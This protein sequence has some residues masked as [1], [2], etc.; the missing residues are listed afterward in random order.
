KKKKKKKKQQPQTI[1]LSGTVVHTNPVAVSYSLASGGNLTAVHTSDPSALPQV[2]DVV[3]SNA[4]KLKNGTYAEQAAKGKPARTQQG[5]SGNATFT[6][7]VTFCADV[8]DPAG[9][10]CDGNP[11]PPPHA[12]DQFVYTVSTIGASVLVRSP[13]PIG[14][15]APT[16][17]SLVNVGVNIAPYTALGTVPRPPGACD[18]DGEAN[19]LPS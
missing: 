16:V 5:T 17:G 10:P 6:G 18:T 14:G 4:R 1:N 2:G 11:P 3:N 7:T 12:N 15:A 8:S 19:G 9:V 13:K